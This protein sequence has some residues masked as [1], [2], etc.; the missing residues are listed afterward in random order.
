[1]QTAHRESRAYDELKS[2]LAPTLA[3]S[4]SAWATKQRDARAAQ[5]ERVLAANRASA[6]ERR[7]AELGVAEAGL[8]AAKQRTQSA[9]D[10]LASARSKRQAARLG[11]RKTEGAWAR[12]LS[13]QASIYTVSMRTGQTHE[14]PPAQTDGEDAA[15]EAERA[16]LAEAAARRTAEA[17][18]Q[19]QRAAEAEAEL[20]RRVLAAEEERCQA[21]AEAAAQAEVRARRVEVE[22]AVRRQAEVEAE[23]ETKR[24]AQLDVMAEREAEVLWA[25]AEAEAEAE[26]GAGAE[27]EA[28][29]ATEYATERAELPHEERDTLAPLRLRSD[30][31]DEDASD[32]ENDDDQSLVENRY[33]LARS[34]CRRHGVAMVWRCQLCLSI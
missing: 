18:A 12:S 19:T 25:Q 28:A 5:D 16:A 15:E 33:A 14:P 9:M 27:P 23:A 7:L 1:M 13:R 8:A 10:R 4:S 17:D 2:A 24:L 22:A 29:D 30:D 3:R 34:S 6:E 31:E 32:T 20:R 21:E 26:V 11:L